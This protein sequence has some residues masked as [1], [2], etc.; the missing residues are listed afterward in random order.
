MLQQILASGNQHVLAAGFVL[1]GIRGIFALILDIIVAIACGT[2]AKG[3]GYSAILFGVLGF[4]F[5][6]ITLIVVVVIPRKN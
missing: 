5:S 1:S 3:K 6:L 4:F 2:I